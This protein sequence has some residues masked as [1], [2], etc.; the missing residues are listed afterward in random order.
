[1]KNK[2]RKNGSVLIV[3]VFTIALL[4]AFVAGMMQICSE[5]IQI[6]KNEIYAAQA[7]FIAQAGIADAFARIHGS[8]SLPSNFSSSFAGGSYSV[9]VSGSLPDPNFVSRGI[10]PQG[11]ISD[12]HVDVTVDSGSYAIRIDNIRIN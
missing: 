9:T 3:A 7:N 5:Q 8:H 1:M 6:M 10:S 12:V 2:I 11:F 4:T